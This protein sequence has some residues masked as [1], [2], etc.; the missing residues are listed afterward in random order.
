MTWFWTITFILS[1]LFLL[2][3]PGRIIKKYTNFGLVGGFLVGL[4]V[5]F[6]LVNIFKVWSFPRY[7]FLTIAGF[8]LL[9]ALTWLPLEIFFAWAFTQ[10][11]QWSLATLLGL[12]IITTIY[13]YYL[14]QRGLVIYHNWNLAYTLLMSLIIHIV[15]HFYLTSQVKT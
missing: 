10:E 6:S 4:L 11:G 14:L 3:V 2:P 5:L 9:L 7:D 13:H 15:L 1:L 8:P 12:P